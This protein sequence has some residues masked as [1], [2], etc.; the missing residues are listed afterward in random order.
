MRIAPGRWR[1][2]AAGLGLAFAVLAVMVG[3]GLEHITSTAAG[4]QSLQ[5]DA[6]GTSIANYVRA[7][8]MPANAALVL[9][10]VLALLLICFT[11]SLLEHLTSP[12]KATAAF[13]RLVTGSSVLTASVLLAGQ[14]ASEAMVNITPRDDVQSIRV[15][16]QFAYGMEATVCL[17]LGFLMIATGVVIWASRRLP[18]WVAVVSLILGLLEITVGTA[19][20]G[21]G[22]AP[23]ALWALILAG[24]LFLERKRAERSVG[25]ELATN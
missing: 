18:R 11:A 17:P 16:W 12:G 3:F 1:R 2:T 15:L 5:P 7:N 20:G 21:P 14:I 13:G 10:G 6:S 9:E 22:P 23:A 24:P 25:V 8:A 19:T 4:V